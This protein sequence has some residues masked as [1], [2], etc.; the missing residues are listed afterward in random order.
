MAKYAVTLSDTYNRR[1]I[2]QIRVDPLR[3][4]YEGSAECPLQGE[5]CH[6]RAYMD[7][8]KTPEEARDIIVKMV[9]K[10]LKYAK[11]RHK[12]PYGGFG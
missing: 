5:K 10:H 1:H 4:G 8:G 9:K 2:V 11:A 12:N 6:W 3:K 7:H